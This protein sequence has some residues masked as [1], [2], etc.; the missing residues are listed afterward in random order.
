MFGVDGNWGPRALVMAAAMWTGMSVGGVSAIAQNQ[1]APVAVDAVV[2]EPLSQTVPVLGRLVAIQRGTV[3]ALARGPVLEVHVSVGDRV[4]EGDIL[5][6]QAMDRLERSRDVA[7]EAVDAALA[8]VATA[9]SQQQLAEQ[10]LA[11][12]DKLKG[13]A[14]FSSAQREDKS[15]EVAVRRAQVGEANA[16]VARARA[17]LAEAQ[18]DVD[19][20]IVRAP[21]DGVVLERHTVRGAYMNVGDPAITL[22]NDRYLEV[23]ADVPASRIGGLQ[24]GREVQLHFGDGISY[25]GVVRAVVPEE[26]A[27][28]RTR[29][30]RFIPDFDENTTMSPAAGQ[31]VT[32][33]LPVGE[34]RDVVTVHKDAIMPRGDQN[35][36]FV[37]NEDRTVA[38]RPVQLGEAVGTRFVVLDGLQPGDLVVTRGNERLHPGQAVIWP[39]ADEAGAEARSGT[40]G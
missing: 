37:V 36:V 27:L 10:E 23:E 22:I 21:F 12:L 38:P 2:E 40:S 8:A 33:D 28:T 35:S 16:E 7:K 20:G 15:F 11:R 14:A 31:T 25:G 29:I 1:A 34:A 19:L 39:G 3:A 26:N 32:V 6:T 18:L 13:S 30:V 17:L 9:R 24:M 4:H 5:I